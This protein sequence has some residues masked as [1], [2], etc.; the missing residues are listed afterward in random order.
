MHGTIF[1]KTNHA[2]QETH[3][4]QCVGLA[5]S[6]FDSNTV[7]L[8]NNVR[9]RHTEISYLKNKLVS[10]QVPNLIFHLIYAPY[11]SDLF[12]K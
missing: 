9:K 2:C 10:N 8:H 6:G 11:E 12:G 3:L 4:A 1:G 7:K 5:Q